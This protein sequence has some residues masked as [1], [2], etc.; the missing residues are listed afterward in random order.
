MKYDAEKGIAVV[1]GNATLQTS[2]ATLRADWIEMDRNQKRGT[3]RGHVEVIKDD[4]V[5]K[6]STAVYDWES[7]TG[8]ITDASGVSPPWRFSAHNL[9]QR[10]PD[11]YLLQRGRVT[12]CSLDPPHY[13][14][15]S[16]HGRV[17]VGER[18]NF[19]P[20]L[21]ILMTPLFVV[22]VFYPISSSQK[23]HSSFYPRTVEP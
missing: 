7:S 18:L 13:R 22:S 11:E 3:A 23:I 19:D 12:S 8:S 21:S 14:L 2:T 15:Q 6:G 16:H 1:E 10:S 9:I 20:P 17:Q 4:N 5:L